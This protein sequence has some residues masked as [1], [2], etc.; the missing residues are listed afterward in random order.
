MTA[1]FALSRQKQGFDS[2]WARQISAILNTTA[3]TFISMGRHI[4]SLPTQRRA[5]RERSS[6][7]F[8]PIIAV[9]GQHPLRLKAGIPEQIFYSFSRRGHLFVASPHFSE[10]TCATDDCAVAGEFA[11]EFSEHGPAGAEFIFEAGGHERGIVVGLGGVDDE[12]PG[13]GQ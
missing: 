6:D 12:T 13:T 3:N 7:R 2:P 9:W 5:A 8:A 4:G 1:N 11:V 10:D